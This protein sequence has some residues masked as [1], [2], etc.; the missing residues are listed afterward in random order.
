MKR[1]Y[2]FQVIDMLLFKATEE[3]K[4]IVDHA[5]QRHH[6]VGQYVVGRHKLE[7][8]ELGSKGQTISPFLQNF[9]KT[10]Y[11]WNLVKSCSLFPQI[12]NYPKRLC[13]TILGEDNTVLVSDQIAFTVPGLI[14]ES[15]VLLIVVNMCILLKTL[16]S[17]NTIWNLCKW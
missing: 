17:I 9:Y 12:K 10:N 2:H 16:S 6:V 15:N 7:Q 4:D 3:L 1:F 13:I 8:Q 14:W 5:K 11:F